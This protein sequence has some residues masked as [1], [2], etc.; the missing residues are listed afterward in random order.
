M[1]LL[2]G[3]HG[4]GRKNGPDSLCRH[5][6]I[7][8]EI[9]LQPCDCP[10][11]EFFLAVAYHLHEAVI[12]FIEAPINIDHDYP[13]DVGLDQRT[14]L[15]LAVLELLLYMTLCGHIAEDDHATNDLACYIANG[16]TA[17]IED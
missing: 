3:V 10:G 1:F 15:Q 13:E 11:E 9:Q 7:F 6:L 2:I 8:R 17:D 14:Q 16:C 12:G 4:S 5:L